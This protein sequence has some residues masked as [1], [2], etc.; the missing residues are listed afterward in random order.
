MSIQLKYREKISD[1]LK[2][3]ITAECHTAIK[4]IEEADDEDRRHEAVH[5]SRKAFKKIRAC[6][7][8][9]R[10][11]IHYYSEENKWFRDRGREIS[12]IRDATADIEALDELK[13]Q[14]D[15][16]LYKNSLSGLRKSL[17]NHRKNMADVIFSEEDRLENIR[18]AVEAKVKEVPDWE[19]DI[20]TF[21][22]IRPSIKRTYKRGVK[23]L[24]A[25][26]ENGQIEDFH[27]W[28]KRV[29][30]LRYQIDILNR[31]WP[32]VLETLEDELHDVTDLTGFLHDMYNLQNSAQNLD[33]PFSEAEEK[34]LFNAL[35][36]NQQKYLKT[37]ALL[38]GRKFYTD[39]P[40]DFCDRLAVYWETYHEEIQ[41]KSLPETDNL[42][43]S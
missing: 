4:S 42:E 26:R 10:D 18:E 17:L 8:L 33:N 37:H 43:Y 28:R 19:I 23:G 41:N 30:Y 5:E 7:R 22:D 36:D 29:K 21:D 32:Q 40:S 38:K 12:D 31:L 20:Q 14:Y 25:S 11:E 35:T 24:Q 16:E 34:I 13:K 6:L 15:S 39:S 9:I 27:E 3:L 2:R 1:G